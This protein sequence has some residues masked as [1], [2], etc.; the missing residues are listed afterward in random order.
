MHG[1][2]G[3][4]MTMGIIEHR[5]GVGII[6]IWRFSPIFSQAHFHR[7]AS[8]VG[9]SFNRHP[10]F[11]LACRYKIRQPFG[12]FPHQR[13][14]QMALVLFSLLRSDDFRFLAWIFQRHS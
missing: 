3:K 2:R 7:L 8:T 11:S 13:R 14:S 5:R 1:K 6:A 12:N 9:P 4:Q 10:I